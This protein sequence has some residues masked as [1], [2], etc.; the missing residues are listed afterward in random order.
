MALLT[1]HYVI[2]CFCP[3][4]YSLLLFPF[5]SK[6]LR[7]AASHPSATLCT[8]SSH[9]YSIYHSLFLSSLYTSQVARAFLSC[10]MSHLNIDSNGKEKADCSA[11]L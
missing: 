6:C 11:V 10:Y 8:L 2:F 3:F 9:I 7:P 4:S 5:I 1:A